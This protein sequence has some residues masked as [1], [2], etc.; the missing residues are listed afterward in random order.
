MNGLA[1][2]G[3]MSVKDTIN[4]IIA[5]HRA[6]LMEALNITIKL[7]VTASLG[8]HGSTP[9]GSGYGTVYVNDRWTA[10]TGG[11]SQAMNGGAKEWNTSF[12][13]T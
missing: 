2:A 13:L 11:E 6:E 5:E 7:K 12:K 4:W 3:G 1:S 8:T 10:G 9:Y